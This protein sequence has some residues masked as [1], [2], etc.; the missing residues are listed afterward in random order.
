MYSLL[1]K[2]FIIYSRW[3]QQRRCVLQLHTPKTTVVVPDDDPR[4]PLVPCPAPSLAV[5]LQLQINRFN[6]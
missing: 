4:L 5:T 2:V 6:R 1:P 3:L